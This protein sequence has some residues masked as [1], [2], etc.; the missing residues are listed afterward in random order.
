VTIAPGE[1]LLTRGLA[2]TG[3][4]TLFSNMGATRY[5]G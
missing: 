3:T 1:M 2:G 4:V 5:N